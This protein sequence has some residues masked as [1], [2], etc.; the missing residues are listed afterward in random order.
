MDYP[1]TCTPE[2]SLPQRHTSI[3]NNAILHPAVK[4]DS[5]LTATTNKT[6]IMALKLHIVTSR[7]HIRPDCNLHRF[8]SADDIAVQSLKYTW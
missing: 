8:Y 1:T 7:P 5:L 2:F 3:Q 4:S 6:T